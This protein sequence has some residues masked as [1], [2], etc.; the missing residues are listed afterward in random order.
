[1]N[2]IIGDSRAK[3]IGDNVLIKG[4]AEVIHRSGA[5]FPQVSAMIND[6]FIYNH[7]G[8]PIFHGDTHYYIM[9]GIC[10]ATQKLYNHKNKYQEIVYKEKPHQTLEK[11]RPKYTAIVREVKELGAVPILCT[12]YPI[13][14]ENWNRKRLQQGKTSYLKFSEHYPEMQVQLNEAVDLINQHIINTNRLNMVTTP[15]IHR[16]IQHN[17]LKARRSWCLNKLVDGCHPGDDLKESAAR[18]LARAIELN[19]S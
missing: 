6:H 9:A 14:L 5:N 19:R 10:E 13:E 16:I 12:L 1:M 15:M 3:G 2:I 7:G 17:R 8:H 18:S 4:R 11:L